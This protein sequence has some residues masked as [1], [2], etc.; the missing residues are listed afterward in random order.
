MTRKIFVTGG[1]YNPVTIRHLITLTGKA[2][3]KICF[4]PTPAGDSEAHIQKWFEV[5]KSLPMQPFVQTVFVSSY[6]QKIPFEQTLLEM[7]AILVTGGN[8]LNALAL[9]KVQ[10]IDKVLRRAWEKGIV[11]SGPSAG[12]ICWFE[13]GLSD[14][15]PM[16]LSAVTGLGFLKGS[17]CPHYNSE[18]ERRPMY[19]KLIEQGELQP[20]Y[21]CDQAAALY[22]ENSELKKVL[23][24][25]NGETAYRVSRNGDKAIETPLEAELI[26]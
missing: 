17:N 9:W 24:Q 13:Q 23:T 15:R 12:A 22:F 2:K 4:L 16:H 6:D 5:A 26:E 11:L 20:G 10:G 1:E 8:T 21:A 19:L 25:K 14:S 7:D 18:K 3:P